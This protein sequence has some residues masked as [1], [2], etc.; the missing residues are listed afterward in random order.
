MQLLL[1]PWELKTCRYHVLYSSSCSFSLVNVILNGGAREIP[2][3]GKEEKREEKPKN[4]GKKKRSGSLEAA[5]CSFSPTL[6]TQGRT[7]PGSLFL[8]L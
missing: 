8:A 3:R 6:D 2:I 1:Q 7:K 4:R 5:L